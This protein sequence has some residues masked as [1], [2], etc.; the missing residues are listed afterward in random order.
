MNL[1]KA[2]LTMGLAVIIGTLPAVALAADGDY[3]RFVNP[4]IVLDSWSSLFSGVSLY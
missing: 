1:R 4:R 2:L 3:T